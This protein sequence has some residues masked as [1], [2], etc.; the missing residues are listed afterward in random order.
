MATVSWHEVEENMMKIWANSGDSH[1]LEPDDM[2]SSSLPDRLK[3]RAPRAVVDE[4]F[5]TIYVDGVQIR[6]I[7]ASFSEAAMRPPG[8]RNVVLREKDMDETG[9]WA[10]LAFPSRAIWLAAAKDPEVVAACATVWNDWFYS[11]IAKS[12]PRIVGA[13][14]IPTL[15]INDAV[16]EVER[17]AE[18]GFQAIFMPTIFNPESAY[19]LER[20]DP[21][22][23][24]AERA[25]TLVAFHIGTGGDQ[26]VFRGRGAELLNYVETALTGQQIVAQMVSS[27]VLERHPDLNMM[28][29]EGG[30]SWVPA[31]ADRMEEAYRQHADFIRDRLTASPRE[32][33]FRQV[34]TSFQHDESAVAAFTAMGYENVM[35]GD[36]YPH[37][38]GTF[39]HTQETLHHLF[40]GVDEATTEM[41]TVGTFER[42]FTI[43]DRVAA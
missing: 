13:A 15:D 10:Q 6:R 22:W 21:L 26:V 37:L 27:G 30:A 3:D 1:I 17:I 42:L 11:E 16:K 36:D 18:M 28:I 7:L 41:M 38:E 43:P 14:V 12:H 24:A 9:I 29:A 39:G 2:W 33:I 40:D 8:A 4:K 5:E 34:F 19:H 32:T 31:L 35:W 20:W 23:D 25:G